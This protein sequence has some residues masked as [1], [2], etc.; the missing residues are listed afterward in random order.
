MI[1]VTVGTQL[2][3]DRLV[4]TVDEWAGQYGRSDVFAQ[5]GPTS[6][7][8]QH[9]KW[10]PFIDSTECRERT[11]AADVIVSHAGMGTILTALELGKPIVVFPRR[12]DLQEHRNDHQIATAKRFLA[13]GRVVA[14]F[15]EEHLLEKLRHIDDL[16][17]PD[18][19]S[20][21]ASSRLLNALRAFAA[22]G[23]VAQD[24]EVEELL[25]QSAGPAHPA[26][27]RRQAL[28]VK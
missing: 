24:A 22:D 14:A 18:R 16:R 9:I 12:A 1:F 23:S 21:Q 10:A 3:F 6:Y 8:P 27:V 17:S 26:S 7:R 19:I 5:V 4:R 11:E 13:A 28:A 15:D 20:N 2:P 25:V